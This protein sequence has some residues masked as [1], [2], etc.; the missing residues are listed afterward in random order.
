MVSVR[1]GLDR[2]GVTQRL[3]NSVAREALLAVT[4][5]RRHGAALRSG[6]RLWLARLSTSGPVSLG[7]EQILQDLPWLIDYPLDML[8][9]CSLHPIAIIG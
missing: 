8:N 4:L 1:I 5:H 9:D 2:L 7:G 3:L 6:G